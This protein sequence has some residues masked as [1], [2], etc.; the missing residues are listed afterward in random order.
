MPMLL[1]SG[2]RKISSPLGLTD[3]I[4]A[5][6]SEHLCL[7]IKE[8]SRI[9]FLFVPTDTAGRGELLCWCF[10]GVRQIL[11]KR[12]SVISPSSSRNWL[13]KQT[14]L[15]FVG[16]FC[17]FVFYAYWQFQLGG[18]DLCGTYEKQGRH[19]RSSL[20]CSSSLEVPR[21]SAF[22]PPLQIFL[23]IFCSVISRDF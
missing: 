23:C 15:G 19:S 22:F 12:F 10:T 7:G 8:G 14:F 18:Y 1:L 2:R 4:L 5:R 21:P 20:L 6:E 16:V 3:F 11:P 13:W 17:S 9:S